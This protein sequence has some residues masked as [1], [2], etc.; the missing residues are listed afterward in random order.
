MVLVIHHNDYMQARYPVGTGW[1]T[2]TRVATCWGSHRAG[3]WR[4]QLSGGLYSVTPNPSLQTIHRTYQ[5]A[6]EGLVV[7]ITDYCLDQIGARA[8][9]GIAAR[10]HLF[11]LGF[12]SDLS[13]ELIESS[14]RSRIYSQDKVFETQIAHDKPRH[15]SR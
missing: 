13:V 5:L 3:P 7:G 11:L 14:V 15:K 10:F 1:C 12:I 8:I 4:P 6:G 9:P 2:G